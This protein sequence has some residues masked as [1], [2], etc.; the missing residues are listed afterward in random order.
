MNA[1]TSTVL[2]VSKDRSALR[3]LT[4]VLATTGCRVQQTSQREQAAAL[5]A[6][7]PSD[8]LILDASTSL[9]LALGILQIADSDRKGRRPY[10]LLI[11]DHPT[12]EELIAA[13]EAGANDFLT[14]P[15]ASGELLARVRAGRCFRR[16]ERRLLDMDGSHT[17]TG[18]PGFSAFEH[19]LRRELSRPGRKVGTPSLVVVDIDFYHAIL[20]LHGETVATA[21]LRATGQA[22]RGAADGSASVYALGGDRFA[23]ILPAVIEEGAALWAER[24]RKTLAELDFPVKGQTLRIAAS[25]GVAGAAA[26][27]DAD[28]LIWNVLESLG[29]AKLSGRDCVARFGEFVAESTADDAVAPLKLLQD[30]VARDIFIPCDLELRADDRLVE[31]A[32][33]FRRTRLP[34]FPVVDATGEVAGLLTNDAVRAA[35]AAGVAAKVADV[36]SLDVAKFD[37][38]TDFLTLLQYFAQ[39]P[40]AVAIVVRD[41]RPTG[42]L[43]SDTLVTPVAS[44][45]D[46]LA[47]EGAPIACEH[48]MEADAVWQGATGAPL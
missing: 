29:S 8:V 9:S 11:V 2:L 6:A 44:T 39:H 4:T 16:C 18:L 34:A 20:R 38:W 21:V 15:V 27:E 36:M 47:A 33:L 24:T 41:G 40:D 31:V 32:A 1:S 35:L 19:R 28:R 7:D 30:S 26:E 45:E 48:L 12:R 25:C 43:T 14:K 3:R 46:Y 10:T 13:V 37:E 42:L 22:L 23:A 5:L 17:A